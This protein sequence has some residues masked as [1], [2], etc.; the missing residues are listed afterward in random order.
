MPDQH[1]ENL[2]FVKTRPLLRAL[3]YSLILVTL[4]LNSVFLSP[5]I[6]CQ[7]SSVKFCAILSVVLFRSSLNTYSLYWLVFQIVEC[8]FAVTSKVSGSKLSMIGLTVCEFSSTCFD[9]SVRWWNVAFDV[10]KSCE[11]VYLLSP[12]FI[13]WNM[14]ETHRFVRIFI[15]YQQQLMTMSWWIGFWSSLLW[16]QRRQ[17]SQFVWVVIAR[18]QPQFVSVI[19]NCF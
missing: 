4:L 6:F 3:E 1:E 14:S 7:S 8:F 18:Q 10:M 17:Q 11:A 13:K 5:S 9:L 16:A 12:I 19:I 2:G 15:T